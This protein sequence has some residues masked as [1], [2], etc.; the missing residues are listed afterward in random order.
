MSSRL[1]PTTLFNVT[2]M[3]N[4]NFTNYDIKPPQMLNYLRYNGP[5]FTKALAE[6]AISKMT[7]NDKKIKSLSK[8][9]VDLLLTNNKIDLKYNQLYDYVYVANMIMAD[10][11]GESIE[12]DLHMSRHIKCI[13]DDTD[14]YDG[15]VFNRWYA[16]MSALGI[17]IDWDSVL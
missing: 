4:V 13:I 5:H 17:A 7:R 15:L 2:T 3:Q 16:D 8:E 11:I 6:F 9:Q 10:F 1:S 12:D 14:G